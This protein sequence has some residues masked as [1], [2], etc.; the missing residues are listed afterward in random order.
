MEFSAHL[1]DPG[2]LGCPSGMEGRGRVKQ[3]HR[4]LPVTQSMCCVCEDGGCRD[5]AQE[6]D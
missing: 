3:G 1:P 5:S 6:R 4:Q 2:E